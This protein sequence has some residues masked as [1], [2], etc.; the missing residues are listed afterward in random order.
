MT[1]VPKALSGGTVASPQTMV[2]VVEYAPIHP[3]DSPSDR[4]M[5]AGVSAAVCP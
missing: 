3:A 4:V 2:G 1:T 5:I